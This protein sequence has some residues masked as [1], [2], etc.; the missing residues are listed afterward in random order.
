M[1]LIPRNDAADV[2]YYLQGSGLETVVKDSALAERVIDLFSLQ[3]YTVYQQALF[4]SFLF[5]FAGRID[6]LQVLLHRLDAIDTGHGIPCD[7]EAF[8]AVWF[9]GELPQT[10]DPLLEKFRADF[11]YRFADRFQAGDA[12]LRRLA[13]EFISLVRTGFEQ[14]YEQTAEQLY[15]REM[16]IHSE[17]LNDSQL[18]QKALRWEYKYLGHDRTLVEKRREIYL[19]RQNEWLKPD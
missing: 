1:A 9:D 7:S 11:R 19:K 18:Q 3:E 6:R 10:P 13:D 15:L 17:E 2:L 16:E 14:F 8:L 4:V 12:V 5:Y